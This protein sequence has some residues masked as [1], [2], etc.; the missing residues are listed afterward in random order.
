MK[1]FKTYKTIYNRKI[2]KIIKIYT[3]YKG[4]ENGLGILW[5]G[6]LIPIILPINERN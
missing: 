1:I 5:N 4:F 3:G 2:P 6:Y